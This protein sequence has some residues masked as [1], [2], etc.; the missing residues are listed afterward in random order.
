MSKR[1]REVDSDA[2]VNDTGKAIFVRDIKG[3]LITVLPGERMPAMASAA[4]DSARESVAKA[5]AVYEEKRLKERTPEEIH[6]EAYLASKQNK[7]G[8]V[9]IPNAGQGASDR[10]AF[11]DSLAAE[12]AQHSES[13]GKKYAPSRAYDRGRAVKHQQQKHTS[14]YLGGTSAEAARIGACAA[15]EAMARALEASD[16]DDNEPLNMNAVQLANRAMEMYNIPI[17]ALA[18]VLSATLALAYS[19]GCFK[20]SLPHCEFITLG[21]RTRQ[22]PAAAKAAAQSA[23]VPRVLRRRY[24]HPDGIGTSSFAESNGKGGS[25]AVLLSRGLQLLANIDDLKRVCVLLLRGSQGATVL[26]DFEAVKKRYNTVFRESGV[27]LR[28]EVCA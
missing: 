1:Q 13:S 23:Q 20:S 4:S 8:N 14:G 12:V 26:K 22:R 3:D 18:Q 17:S 25:H 11:A 24:L 19:L 9:W 21:G 6:Y 2:P 10:A 28:G 27:E 5:D 7:G 16:N 15:N